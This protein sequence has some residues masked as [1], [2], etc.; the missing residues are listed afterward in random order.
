MNSIV[1]TKL[2]DQLSSKLGKEASE[3]LIVFIE[4]KVKEESR[5]PISSLATG[6]EDMLYRSIAETEKKIRFRE[7]ILCLL[8]VISIIMEIALFWMGPLKR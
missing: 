5:K 6:E 2:Y 1:I 8:L 4:Q 3:S 7:W